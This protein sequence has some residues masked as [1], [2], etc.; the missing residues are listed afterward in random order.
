MNAPLKMSEFQIQIAVVD[1]LKARALPSV[2][3]FAVPNGGYVMDPRVV[4]KLK[5]MGL[6]PGA[7]DIVVLSDGV[8]R[9]LELKTTTGTQSDAQKQAMKDW[10]AAG[11]VYEVARGLDEA[12]EVL[13][14]WQVLR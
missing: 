11:G 1:H 9:G 12:L 4:A 7:P 6:R 8:P 10:R 3:W 14:R 2:Y 13:T 5:A